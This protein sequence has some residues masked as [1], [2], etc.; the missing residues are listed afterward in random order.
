MKRLFVLGSKD[1]EMD[2]V[3]SLLRTLGEEYIYAKK[4]NKRVS[5]STAYTDGDIDEI[6]S[7][8][9]T[10][11]FVECNM[12]LKNKDLVIHKIDHHFIGDFGY[13]KSSKD[14]WNAS[15][16]GQVWNMLK[17]INEIPPKKYR[18][19]AAAD[20]CLRKAY[21]GECVNINKNFLLDRR[22]RIKAAFK[23]KT[24]DEIKNNISYA[25]KIVEKIKELNINIMNVGGEKLIDLR[26]GILICNKCKDIGIIKDSKPIYLKITDEECVHEITKWTPSIP[27][28]IEASCISEVA[29][30]EIVNERD[31][32]RKKVLLMS[33]DGRAVN[34]FLNSM[35]AEMDLEEVYG[36]SARGFAGGY[37]K[38]NKI[39]GKIEV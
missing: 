30:L 6:D 4:N 14:Y 21:A 20:H 15:S 12:N 9:D 37:K 1:I 18:Y 10:V 26:E 39:G 19:I 17:P 35:A 32:Q 24:Q 5:P 27:E 29:V 28:I 16:L 7:S 31:T 34:I 13:G 22:I 38:H 11:I 25:L 23:G 36:D 3:E 2:A 33:S 8:Y